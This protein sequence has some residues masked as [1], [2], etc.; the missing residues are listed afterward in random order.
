MPRILAIHGIGQQFRADEVIRGEWWPY[1]V[2]GLHKVGGDLLPEDFVCP[3][4][5]HL[6]R[7][8]EQLSTTQ[9]YNPEDL[10][11]EEVRLMEI[12]LDE[13]AKQE[14]DKVPS[15]DAFEGEFLGTPGWVQWAL[16]MLSQSSFFSNISQSMMIGDLKQVVRYMNDSKTR[17]NIIEKVLEKFTPDIRIVIGHSLGSIIAYECLF[18]KPEQPVCF[19]TLGSPLG[20]RNLIFDKLQPAPQNGKGIWPPVK[21]WTNVADK[22]DV[23]AL[24]K[25]L[26]RFF[27]PGIK[28]IVVDNGADAHNG[29]HYLS[30]SAIAN[31]IRDNL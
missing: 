11:P 23:V 22:G 12:L 7:A 25:E 1:L 2:G 5:G 15:R 28:D 6:F 21:S 9:R 4:Y 3:F 17:E 18:R 29:A 30:S 16:R 14:P 31:I 27:G 26:R 24:N 19:I 8:H 10:T 13:A 20:I